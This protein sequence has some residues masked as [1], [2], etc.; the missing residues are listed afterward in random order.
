MKQKHNFYNLI[1]ISILVLIV[2]NV[3]SIV[4]ESIPSFNHYN[5]FFQRF[6]L[7]SVVVFSIEYV[8]RILLANKFYN[9]GYFKSSFR[10][11]LSFSGLIDLIS[12]LPFYLPLIFGFDGRIL[13]ILRLLRLFRLFKV[14]SYNDSISILL[15]VIYSKRK[16]L[17]M[18]LYT[19]VILIILSSTLMFE[20]ENDIQPE[21]FPTILHSFWWSVA[22]LTTIG[23]G[24]IYP[25]T[26]I[27]KLLASIT[28]LLGIGLVA[29]PTGVISA[30]FL[31]KLQTKIKE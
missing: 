12:I 6:E 30:G 20:I 28:A 17:I 24:D 1:E 21:N 19:V 25:I 16:I 31:E 27:G 3:I 11:I 14:G 23:Y 15:E 7:F 18:T 26:G 5:L 22:T 2:L 4:L 8:S 13:R 10:Y 9:Q 29:I